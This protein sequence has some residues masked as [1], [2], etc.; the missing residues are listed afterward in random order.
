MANKIISIKSTKKRSLYPETYID[1]AR[2]STTFVKQNKTAIE[3]LNRNVDIDAVK[4]SIRNIF[5]WNK[6]ERVLNPEFGINLRQ[7]LYEGITDLTIQQIKAEI[8]FSI[9]TYE[10]RVEIDEVRA[11]IDPNDADNNQIHIFVVYHIVGL[12]EDKYI[13]RVI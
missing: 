10:P 5:T 13:Q 4:G 3:V 6:G 9:K 1:I 11:D 7:Y 12:P 2:T 8:D